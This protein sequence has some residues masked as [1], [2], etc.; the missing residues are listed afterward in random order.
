[1]K[2]QQYQGPPPKIQKLDI[3]S[4]INEVKHSNLNTKEDKINYLKKYKYIQKDYNFLYNIIINND[5]KNGKS[6]ELNILNQM[7]SKIEDINDKKVSKKKGEEEIGQVLVD[8][9][10]M[11]QIER[12]KKE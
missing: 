6:K 10:I 7:L 9:Y 8:E 12:S 5:L 2:Q 4:I 1:M 3:R 11:P